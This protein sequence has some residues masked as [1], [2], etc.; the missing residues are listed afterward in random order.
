MTIRV[1]YRGKSEVDH[2]L[3]QVPRHENAFNAQLST[4]I[5]TTTFQIH[6]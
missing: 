5:T 3:N 6:T 4:T 2:V 1:K